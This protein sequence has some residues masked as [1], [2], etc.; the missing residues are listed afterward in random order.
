MVQPV[1]LNNFDPVESFMKGQRIA[2]LYDQRKLGQLAMQQEQQKLAKQQQF[3]DLYKNGG[4]PT[5]DQAYNIDPTYGQQVDQQQQDPHKLA[6]VKQISNIIRDTALKS[7]F[8]PNDPNTQPILDKVSEP[9]RPQIA[10]I[11]GVQDDPSKPMSYQHLESLAGLSPDQQSQQDIKQAVAKQTALNDVN[12]PFEQKK[13]AFTNGDKT[14]QYT[15]QNNLEN[16]RFEHQKQLETMKQ[17]APKPASELQQYKIDEL[18]QKKQAEYENSVAVIDDT[19]DEFNRLKEIQKHTTTGPVAS[20]EFMSGIRKALP[21]AIGGG[22]NLQRLQQGYSTMAVKAL[23]AFKASG[24]TFGQ[25]SNAEGKWVQETTAKLNYG[26]EINQEILDQGIKLLR[27]RKEK[28]AKFQGNEQANLPTQE[29][30]N[31]QQSALDELGKKIQSGMSKEQAFSE[32]K[33]LGGK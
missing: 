21:D 26:G 23:A 16:L 8:N 12:L 2:A 7:G 4:R 31:M 29:N 32:Y 9:Y 17:N 20:N 27:E 1:E 15:Q 3:A 14:Q 5:A 10:Q 6:Y 19:I 11:F 33:R 22:D 24:V 13:R 28:G 18:K 30:P 25:L